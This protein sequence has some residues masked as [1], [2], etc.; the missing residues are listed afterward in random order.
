MDTVENVD[1]GNKYEKMP[2]GRE[3]YYVFQSFSAIADA[4]IP[5]EADDYYFEIEVSEDPNNTG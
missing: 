5:Y 2:D 4:P 3:M 1:C